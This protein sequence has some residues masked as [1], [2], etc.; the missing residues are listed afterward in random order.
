MNNKGFAFL[1]LIFLV[2]I[3]SIT[4]LLFSQVIYDVWGITLG[5]YTREEIAFFNKFV[6]SKDLIK[7]TYYKDVEDDVLYD[8]A[9]YGMASALGDPYTSYLGKDVDDLLSA[10]LDGEYVGIGIYVTSDENNVI[11]ITE[12]IEGGPADKAGLLADDKIL[13]VDG[14]EYTGE[15]LTEAV[16]KI[17]ANPGVEKKLQILRNDEK[18]EKTIKT[19]KV[20]IEHVKSKKIEDIG[21]IQ[22]ESFDKKSASQFNKAYDELLNQNIKAL[23][24]DLRGNSGGIYDDVIEI[25]K[26]IVPQGLI[27]YTEDKNGKKD[28][29]YAEGE[30]IKVPLAVLIDGGSA[31]ASEVL[32]GA[33][34]DRGC[35]ILVGQNTFGKGLVQAWYKMTDGTSIKVTISK[36]FTPNGECIEGKGI[37]PDVE[38]KNNGTQDKQLAKAIEL[39]KKEI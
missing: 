3:T 17:K 27:V 35:G 32:A 18:I 28:E 9:F 21:Y 14:V 38:V 15:D 19:E 37:A 39:L 25:A 16:E 22:I 30:G 2:V 11:Y 6:A 23:I 5:G 26:R 1:G 34:K 8:G 24:I 10:E 7:E 20:I 12:V 13:A 31:S 33:V 4:T 36:Y 29:I